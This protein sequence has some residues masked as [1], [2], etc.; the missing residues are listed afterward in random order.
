MK[1]SLLIFPYEEGLQILNLS[2][3]EMEMDYRRTCS[4][5]AV[6]SGITWEDRFVTLDNLYN[7]IVYN[8][9]I[10]QKEMLLNLKQQGYLQ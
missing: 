1:D 4:F 9:E 10:A 6:Y 8:H 5:Q 7:S 3:F 2:S